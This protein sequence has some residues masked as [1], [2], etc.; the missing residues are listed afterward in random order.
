MS[1]ADEIRADRLRKIGNVLEAAR[2][3]IRDHNEDYPDHVWRYEEA[4]HVELAAALLADLR[5]TL[6]EEDVSAAHDVIAE[7][8]RDVLRRFVLDP[9][10]YGEFAMLA[11]HRFLIDFAKRGIYRKD[12]PLLWE[13]IGVEARPLP[14]R[15]RETWRGD[16]DVPSFRLLVSIPAWMLATEYERRRAVHNALMTV[17]VRGAKQ[18][19]DGSYTGGTPI[20]RQPD[21]VAH[22]HTLIRYGIHG[23]REVG[24][25]SA[26]M[27]HPST[28]ER[29]RRYRCDDVGQLAM[30][31]EPGADEHD[32]SLPDPEPRAIEGGEEVP[33]PRKATSKARERV[34]SRKD[35]A[36]GRD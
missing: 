16:G 24:A 21:I 8:V 20:R 1:F 17:G 32:A 11:R 6:T 2:E 15:E 26:A 25:I 13:V 35:V 3:R 10:R 4:S 33:P 14:V 31:V 29:I 28:A 5:P 30:Y 9:H 7:E 18:E 36:S 27:A 23:R 22:S 12:G 19:K 34:R